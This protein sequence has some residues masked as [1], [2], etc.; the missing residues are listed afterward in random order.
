MYHL[1]SGNNGHIVTLALDVA[2]AQRNGIKAGH[3][4]LHG[5]HGFVLHKHHGVV[6]VNGGEHQTQRILRCGGKYHLQ[7]GDMGDPCLQRLGVLCGGADTGTGGQTHHH[8]HGDLAPEHVAHLSRLIDQLV[9]ADGQ[10]VDKHQLCD[11]AQTGGSSTNG[12]ADDG[13][14]RDGSVLDALAAELMKHTGGNAKAAAESANVFAEQQDIGVLTH[15]D[16]HALTNCFSIGHRFHLTRTS[17][18]ISE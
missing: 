13:A 7:T 4:A 3:L 14:F 11:G 8:G 18:T 9:H 17:S 5:V 6:I 1:T 2:F 10:K 15:P 16:A 12:H